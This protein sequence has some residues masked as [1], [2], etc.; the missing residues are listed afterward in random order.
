MITLLANQVSPNFLNLLFRSRG[1]NKLPV[2][3]FLQSSPSKLAVSFGTIDKV[4]QNDA[5][6]T[7]NTL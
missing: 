5:R 1:Q 3:H 2:Q 4:V 7:M 6:Y